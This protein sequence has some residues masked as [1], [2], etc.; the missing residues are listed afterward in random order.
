[1]NGEIQPH[2]FGELRIFVSELTD[3]V[4]GPIFICVNR[5]D[6]GSIAIEIAIDDGSYRRQLGDEIHGI[7]IDGLVKQQ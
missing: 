3:K 2:E 1:M 6:A 7:L 4:G 5:S